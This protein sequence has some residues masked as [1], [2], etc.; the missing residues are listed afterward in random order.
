MHVWEMFELS[1][2]NF[3]AEIEKIEIFKYADKITY[4]QSISTYRLTLITQDQSTEK[5][6]G[7]YIEN[8]WG[9][10]KHHFIAKCQ[11]KYL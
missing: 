8:A 10:A 4:K 6:L 11:F 9:L 5:I 3:C 1:K 2:E 7:S